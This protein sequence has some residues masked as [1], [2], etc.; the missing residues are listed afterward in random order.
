MPAGTAMCGAP[1]SPARAASSP[2]WQT[3]TTW[4]PAWAASVAASSVSSVAPEH[5][6]ASTSVRDPTK[7]GNS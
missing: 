5:D 4:A 6:T 3:A 1:H 7:P 2:P